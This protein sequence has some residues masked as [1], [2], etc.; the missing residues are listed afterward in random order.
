LFFYN[1]SAGKKK[2]KS[3]PVVTPPDALVAELV[4]PM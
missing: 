3:V 1:R 2:K 4:T